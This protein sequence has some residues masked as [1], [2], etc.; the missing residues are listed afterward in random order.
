M[1]QKEKKSGQC[2]LCRMHPSVYCIKHNGHTVNLCTGCYDTLIKENTDDLKKFYPKELYNFLKKTIIGQD[3]ALK[4][5][6]IGVYQHYFMSSKRMKA[7]MLIVGPTGTGKT[8]I[9]RQLTRFLD[10]PVLIEDT[11]VYTPAGYKGKDLDDMIQ[12]LFDFCEQDKE[13]TETAIII[14]DEFD[15]VTTQVDHESKLHLA[16]QQALLKILEGKNIG[17]RNIRERKIEYINT[18]RILFICM[19][20]FAVDADHKK[21][22]SIGFIFHPNDRLKS[23]NEELLTKGL[24]P[25]LLGR[26]PYIVKLEPLTE[27]GLYELVMESDISFLKEYSAMFYLQNMEIEWSKKT[28]RQLCEEAYKKQTGVRGVQQ[29]IQEKIEDLIFEIDSQTEMKKIKI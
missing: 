25:E 29:A 4:K 19:G 18:S 22:S 8:E 17:V 6:A 2:E 13:K 21:E 23:H 9:A 28:V 3:K 24:I 5:V 27:S 20:S 12:D 16:T 1:A 26:F 11:S 15:K 7:N 10:R 14:L